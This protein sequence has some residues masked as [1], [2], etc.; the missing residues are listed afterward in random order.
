MS[1]KKQKNVFSKVVERRIAKTS[2]SPTLAP[3]KKKLKLFID[4]LEDVQF[5][6]N[7]SHEVKIFAAVSS[8][9]LGIRIDLFKYGSETILRFYLKERYYKDQ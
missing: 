9:T 5:K 6:I 3:L 2:S 7:K 8:C 4:K 1:S